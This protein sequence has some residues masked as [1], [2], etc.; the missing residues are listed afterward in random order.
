[1]CNLRSRKETVRGYL[2]KAKDFGIRNILALRGDSPNE[3]YDSE[4]DPD[5][6]RRFKYTSDLVRVIK[7][8]YADDFT[9]VVAGYPRGHP[10]AGSYEED[11]LNLKKKVLI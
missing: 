9:V 4:N 7:E 11:L 8:E 2:D 1:M 5:A 10:D 6:G 3:T